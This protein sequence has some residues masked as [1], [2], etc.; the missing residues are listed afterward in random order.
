M[1]S[2]KGAGSGECV[3]WIFA[4]RRESPVRKLPGLAKLASL[5]AFM[6][7]SNIRKCRHR[8]A[9][10]KRLS[11]A[12]W[13]PSLSYIEL[14]TR[15][16]IHDSTKSTVFACFASNKIVKVSQ[17][18]GYNDHFPWNACPVLARHAFT[19]LHVRIHE[20]EITLLYP[21][22]EIQKCSTNKQT[23]WERTWTYPALVIARQI[24]K[25][26]PFRTINLAPNASNQRNIPRIEE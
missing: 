9:S 18:S 15:S 19:F 6:S 17:K 24:K 16:Y 12:S 1:R 22:T 5:M 7:W 8:S 23:F 20:W 13:M 3:L 10:C 26:L 21:V 25:H 2:T 4:S 14:D 11:Q